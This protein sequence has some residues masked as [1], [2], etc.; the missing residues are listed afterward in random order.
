MILVYKDLNVIYWIFGGVLLTGVAVAG[1]ADL[2]NLFP[3]FVIM[4]AVMLV[5]RYVLELT[6]KKRFM[7]EVV[8]LYNNCRV[9]EYMAKIEERLGTDNR[10]E[11]KH[12]YN[13]LRS[14]DILPTTRKQR[15]AGNSPP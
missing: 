15:S 2:S 8:P 12:F 13:Y 6:G 3:A 5:V 4:F 11:I 10:K 14:A 9:N 1:I 7:N